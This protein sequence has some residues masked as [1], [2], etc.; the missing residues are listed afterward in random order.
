[1]LNL[2]NIIE[3]KAK[4][5]EYN[6]TIFNNRENSFRYYLNKIEIDEFRHIK[7]L[8][9]SFD[10]PVTVIT[11]NNKIGKTSILL[12]I[13]CSHVEFKKYDSTKLDSDFRN[14]NWGDVLTFTNYENSQRNYLY[15][16]YWRV[17]TDNRN[18]EGKRLNT[19]RAWTGLGKFSSD[20]GRTN[21]KIRDREVRLIDLERLLPARNFSKTLVRKIG[22]NAGQ[23][24]NQNIED[25]FAFILDIPQTV[26]ITKIGSHINKVAYLINYAGDS[27]SS[28][29]AASGEESLINIL[30]DIFESP[31]DSLILIDEIE[32]GFH[33]SVQ[34]KL[35]D[36]IQY[37]A[38]RQKKQ[39]IIT[40]HSPSLLSAFN[41][42]SRKYI[43]KDQD[44]NFETVN[45]IS[46]NSA[47]SKM[48]TVA[49]PL[50]NL[51]CEDDEAAFMIRAML[52]TI[53]QEK[54]FFDRLVNVITSGPINEVRNDYIRHRRNYSQLKIKTG[55]CAVFDGD[56]RDN[57]LYS[58]YDNNLNEF[59][60]FL[61]PYSAPEKFLVSSYLS[62]NP[63]DRLATA[64]RFSDHHALFQEMVNLG[65]AANRS[66]ARELCWNEFQLTPEYSTLFVQ[67]KQF[68]FR[69]VTHFSIASD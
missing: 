17:G 12:I 42:K 44:G 48:D 38:W 37:V 46:V 60:M 59:T 69:V 47:F 49:Y 65:L 64:L 68:I 11:G 31:N 25:A 34:R 30:V 28:Y 56:Y 66:Q 5:L 54:K 18:G 35:A 29:N 13:A 57:P 19:S 15:K 23:R 32:S 2:N 40:T 8:R 62:T 14:H 67:F 24:V 21:A 16:L 27:Y 50:V 52:V 45:N 39:F 53:N 9:I 61:Y 51:Y 6:P 20:P 55:Y 1:M 63:N 7:G 26:E 4:L 33:P 58:E 22:A 41:Q 3:A 43:D 10:H 36:V